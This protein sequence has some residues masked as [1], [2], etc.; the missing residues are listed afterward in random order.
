MKSRNKAVYAV[1]SLLTDMYMFTSLM[2]DDNVGSRLDL[3]KID[4]FSTYIC[5]LQQIE[6]NEIRS[7]PSF[8]LGYG[9][10]LAFLRF[11]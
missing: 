1:N 2:A 9:L 6:K 8:S 3:N 4:S 10:S 11:L 7:Y 5:H